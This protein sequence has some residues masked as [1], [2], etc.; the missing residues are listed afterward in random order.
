MKT[1]FEKDVNRCLLSSMQQY[2]FLF[3][4]VLITID[5]KISLFVSSLACMCHSFH[6]VKR[7]LETLFVHR[8]SHGTMPLRN[9]FKVICTEN[10]LVNDL[11]ETNIYC[12]MEV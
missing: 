1:D 5:S 12:H 11:G 4:K 7:L 9:I 6:Y 10:C 2:D 3:D 8:F